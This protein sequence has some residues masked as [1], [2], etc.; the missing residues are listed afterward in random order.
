MLHELKII[1]GMF[2][3]VLDGRKTFEFRRDDRPGG[4]HIGD[5][6]LLRE[7]VSC[8]RFKCVC[9]GDYTGR[10]IMVNVVYKLCDALFG[11]PEGFCILGIERQSPFELRKPVPVVLGEG[12]PIDSKYAEPMK[13]HEYSVECPVCK[14]HVQIRISW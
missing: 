5:A 8:D 7:W 13:M 9:R 4:F 6:L 12:S 11:V 1:P 2:E 3:A 10:S 14:H